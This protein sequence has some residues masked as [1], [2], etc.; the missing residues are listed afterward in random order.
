VD[1]TNGTLAERVER[2]AALLDGVRPGW[3]WEMTPE[4][5]DLG[6]CSTCVLGQLYGHFLK[7]T[8]VLFGGSWSPAVQ[9]YAFD[10]STYETP[11]SW[12][13]YTKAWLEAIA[14]RRARRTASPVEVEVAVEVAELALVG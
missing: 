2:G 4:D 14:V 7:G 12:P 8:N 6:S 1:V 9:D 10:R 13:I 11:G 3:E 5:L